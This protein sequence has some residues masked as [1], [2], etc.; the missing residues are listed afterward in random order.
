MVLCALQASAEP[1]TLK[2]FLEASDAQNLDRRIT[3]EQ[4]EKAEAEYRQAWTALLPSFLASV[5][6]THNE[7]E[8]A[9]ALNPLMPDSKIVLTPY[10]QF[11]GILRVDLPLID[12]TRWMRMLAADA[13]REGAQERERVTR[14]LVHKQVVASYYGYAAALALQESAKKSLAVA[15]A[16]LKLTEVRAAAG[17][18][19]ELELLRARA[20]VQRNNQQV[21]DARSLVATSRRGLKTLS[22]VEPPE[23][24]LLPETNR[25]PEP[26]FADLEQKVDELPQVRAADRDAAAAG[27]MSTATKLALVPVIG[28]QFTERLTN[29]T[30]FAGSAALYNLGITA[31]WRIDGPTITGIDAQAHG[32]SIALIAAERARVVARDQIHND[33]QRF[34]AALLKIDAAEAQVQAASRAAQVAR[35]RYNAGAATQVDVIQAERD[36]FTSEFGLIQARF[37]LATARASLRIS[38]GISL[39]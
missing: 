5:T 27:K 20:E 35:D 10:N 7:K 18:V 8:V 37:D 11:D 12:T 3:L 17:S 33:W 1:A 39:D 26:P 28:G 29:A 14:D 23:S 9:F 22:G 30:S 16:Q 19:T 32:E 34:N 13:S 6:W 15:E 2:S 21:V 4:R 38:S 24:V 25:T 31:S 36:L